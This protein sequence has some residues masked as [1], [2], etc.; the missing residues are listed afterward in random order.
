MISSIK[1]NISILY[2]QVPPPPILWDLS[3]AQGCKCLKP[4]IFVCIA[5]KV[6][7]IC[8]PYLI[9]SNHSCPHI[10]EQNKHLHH[11]SPLSALFINK[12]IFYS[13]KRS[14]NAQHAPLCSLSCWR[15]LPSKLVFDLLPSS[16]RCR[17]TQKIL[18]RFQEVILLVV[19]KSRVHTALPPCWF[20]HLLKFLVYI[21]QLRNLAV[22]DWSWNVEKSNWNGSV[23]TKTKD[24]SYIMVMCPA[25]VKSLLN[26]CV[27]GLLQ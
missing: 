4:N 15:R 27:P 6:R 23:R 12:S 19:T 22:M 20:I 8:I 7:H 21:S 16:C 14:L 10:I 3:Q 26:R 13:G 24:R 17:R 11:N 1:I 9:Y 5:K 25:I 18:P 2:C